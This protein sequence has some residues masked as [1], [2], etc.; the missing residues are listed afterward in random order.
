MTS[1]S[2]H[3]FK[4]SLDEYFNEIKLYLVDKI[5]DLHSSD[6]WKNQL[7]IA[8][9]TEEHVIMYSMSNNVKFTFYNDVNEVA[10]ELFES[11]L[12]RYQDN[13]ETPMRGSEFIF[14]SVHLLYYK[15]HKVNS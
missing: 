10:N 8:K 2:R 7:A 6:T 9:G 5:I 11:L 15:C 13:L 4:L 14:E 3:F 1:F 12:L